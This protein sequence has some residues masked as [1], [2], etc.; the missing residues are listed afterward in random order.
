LFY[1]GRQSIELDVKLKSPN[2]GP[3]LEPLLRAGDPEGTGMCSRQHLLKVL[4]L[5]FNVL[6]TSGEE[7]CLIAEWQVMDHLSGEV[8]IQNQRAAER[9]PKD[10]VTPYEPPEGP[11]PR[12]SKEVI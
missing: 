11:N 12:I 1:D 4:M 3:K 10:P 5:H 7:Q 2:L 9:A 6:L 8:R